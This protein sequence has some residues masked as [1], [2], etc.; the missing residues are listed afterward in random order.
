METLEKLAKP[1]GEYWY[2]DVLKRD[3]DDVLK[4]RWILKWLGE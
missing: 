3:N 4:K 1:N 2:G